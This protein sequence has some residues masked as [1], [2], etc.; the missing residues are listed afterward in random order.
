V[1]VTAP[2][3]AA[4]LTVFVTVMA[5]TAHEGGR[6]GAHGRHRLHRPGL[7]HSRIRHLMPTKRTR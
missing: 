1:D 2:L 7:H 5:L 4:L 6:Y 3:L